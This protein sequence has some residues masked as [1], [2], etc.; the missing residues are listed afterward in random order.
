MKH[1]EDPQV[2]AA[3]RILDELANMAEHASLTGSLQG[4]AEHAAR[5]YNRVLQ[6]LSDRG[7]VL[8]GMFEPID[9]TGA[10]FG[11]LGVQCRLLMAAVTEERHEEGGGFEGVVALA[12]FLESHDLGLLVRERMDGPGRLSDGLLAGLAPF[13]DRE[14]LGDLVRRKIAPPAPPRPPQPPQPASPPTSV[15]EAPTMHPVPV[16]AERLVGPTSDAAHLEALATELRRP[17]LTPE[18]RQRIAM[19]L[20]ELAYDQTSRSLP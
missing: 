11:P 15:A 9:P 8:E 6:I 2:A 20:T 7:L 5:S 18:E 16:N 12:P 19:R 1:H 3:R 10:A 4:G 17:D 14:T 13:L